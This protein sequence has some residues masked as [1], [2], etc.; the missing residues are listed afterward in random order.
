MKSKKKENLVL[1]DVRVTD[2]SKLPPKYFSDERVIDILR[3]VIAEDVVLHK[4]RI[5]AGVDPLYGPDTTDSAFRVFN[6]A[7]QG[8]ITNLKL[9]WQGIIVTVVVIYGLLTLTYLALLF[10]GAIK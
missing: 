4:K 1:T 10:S 9:H 5:P 7:K 3:Q 6:I 2:V 8:L